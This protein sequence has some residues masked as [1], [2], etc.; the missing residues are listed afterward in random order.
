MA[1]ILLKPGKSW[2]Q[3][4][5]ELRETGIILTRHRHKKGGFVCYANKALRASMAKLINGKELT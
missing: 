1:R 5:D 3:A 2:T 4:R